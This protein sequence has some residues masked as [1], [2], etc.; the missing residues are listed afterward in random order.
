MHLEVTSLFHVIT[1]GVEGWKGGFTAQV[2]VGNHVVVVNGMTIV[3]SE[4]G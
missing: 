2:V 4:V 3:S 1:G